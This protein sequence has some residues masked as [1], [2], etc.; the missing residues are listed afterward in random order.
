MNS[1]AIRQIIRNM[2][3]KNR[4]DELFSL[5]DR[6]KKID[7]SLR[8][9][10]CMERYHQAGIEYLETKRSSNPFSEEKIHNYQM[11][12][13]NETCRFLIEGGYAHEKQN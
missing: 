9:D 13:V 11:E 10:I 12:K 3:T 6:A 8:R 1:M 5:I 7:P 4:F 2:L